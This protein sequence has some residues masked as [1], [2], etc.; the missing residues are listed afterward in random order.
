[1]CKAQFPREFLFLFLAKGDST[2]KRL[3]RQAVFVAVVKRNF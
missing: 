1:M 2:F 3:V